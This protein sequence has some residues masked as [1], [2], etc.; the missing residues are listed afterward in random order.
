MN[1]RDHSHLPRRK[2]LGSQIIIGLLLAF[3]AVK[4]VD[5]QVTRAQEMVEASE[6]NRLRRVRIPPPRG[7]IF[8]RHGAVLATNEAAYAI[9][10]LSPPDWPP[11]GAYLKQL[12]GLLGVDEGMLLSRF[13]TERSYPYEPAILVPDA[14]AGLVTRVAEAGLDELVIISTPRRVY[15]R[16]ET[17]CHVLGYIDEVRPEE[18]SPRYRMGDLIGRRGLEAVYEAELSGMPG[19]R[20]VEVNALERRIGASSHTT[21]PASGNHLILAIDLEL[22]RMAEE[23]LATLTYRRPYDWPGDEPWIEPEPG[24]RG[25]IILMDVRT[26]EVYALATRPGYDPN[27]VG[28]RADKEY[29]HKVLADPEKPLLARAYQSTY[30]P[31]STFKLVDATA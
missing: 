29:W 2:P 24:L 27:R 18:L 9:G 5:L 4:V 30:P 13:E 3:L 12:C 1:G 21:P 28:V 20:F 25:S 15:P 7:G 26:G 16:G 31:G 11:S 14:D 22:Q 8:D 19:V 23:L 17:L 10:I 6:E